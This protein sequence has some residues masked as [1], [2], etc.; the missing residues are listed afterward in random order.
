MDSCAQLD[1]C[2]ALITTGHGGYRACCSAAPTKAEDV[3]IYTHE[4]LVSPG[5]GYLREIST[6][7]ASMAASR[8]RRRVRPNAKRTPA[9]RPRVHRMDSTPASLTFTGV[10]N[11]LAGPAPPGK[12]A[13]KV[14]K[15]AKAKKKTGKKRKQ[16]RKGKA[17][18]ARSGRSSTARRST[19]GDRRV[20]AMS[21]GATDNDAHEITVKLPA[22]FDASDT[23]P[24]AA[25]TERGNGNE[26]STRTDDRSTRGGLPLVSWLCWRGRCC[27]RRCR[28]VRRRRGHRALY[29][30]GQHLTEAFFST[31]AQIAC[32][33][34][35][36]GLATKWTAYYGSGPAG[37]WTEVNSKEISESARG[38]GPGANQLKSVLPITNCTTMP[39][40]DA[41]FLR[42]LKPGT[43]YDARF[44]AK[45]AD[46]EAPEV[47]IPFKTLEVGEARNRR[48]LQYRLAST[49]DIV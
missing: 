32:E 44:V 13:V 3:F 17:K 1:G 30:R 5:Q 34:A 26:S 20:G 4:K 12:P 6:M 16:G 35:P 21:G 40:H 23:G 25:S 9:R 36:E 31:R 43:S 42:G 15:Q 33:V 22:G 48:K 28:L 46:G 39:R 14:K 38:G 49:G 24:G 18:K 45:N 19:S 10:G 2:V 8:R 47:V 37:P 7:C 41:V 27:W 29:A 11:V